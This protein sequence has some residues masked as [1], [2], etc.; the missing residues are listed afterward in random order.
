MGA[1]R[2]AAERSL[3]LVSSTGFFYRLVQTSRTHR[4]A[5]GVTLDAES[6]GHFRCW[7]AFV[8]QLLGLLQYRR[9]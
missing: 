4:L 6:I 5:Q 7:Q 1:V 9:G 2:S 8:Q 3:L